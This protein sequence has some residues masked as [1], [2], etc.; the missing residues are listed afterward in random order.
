MIL[1]NKNDLKGAIDE[2][3][4]I[5][6]MDLI[7]IKDRVVGCYSISC[8]NMVNIENVIKWLSKIKKNN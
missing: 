6:A 7:A 8:K 4:L 2:K 3:G 5:E 1:G